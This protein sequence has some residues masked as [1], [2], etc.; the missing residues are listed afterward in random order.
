[1]SPQQKKDT[2]STIIKGVLSTIGTVVASLVILSFTSFF[3]EN[4][5]QT[6]AIQRLEVEKANKSDVY[7]QL[8]DLDNSTQHRID[9]N[10]QM[11]N[12]KLDLII[13]LN[14]K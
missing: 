7:Q 8:K 10:Y 14:K 4:D 6:E 11:I 12:E 5:K 2:V 3:D 1:M 13:K 9:Q